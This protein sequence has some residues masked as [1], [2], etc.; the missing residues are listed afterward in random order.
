MGGFG[1]VRTKI[2]LA[3]SVF[4]IIFAYI[5]SSTSYF[6]ASETI[7][8]LNHSSLHQE[9]KAG[10]LFMESH[11]KDKLQITQS[12][13]QNI[14]GAK[15]DDEKSLVEILKIIKDS[16]GFDLTFVGFEKD[17]R[18]FRNNGKHSY[19]KDG[20]DP[21]TR[22]W[23]IDAKKN[24]TAGVSKAYITTTSKEMAVTFYAPFYENGELIGVVGADMSLASL[25]NETLKLKSSANNYAFAIDQDSRII[26]H[27][28]EKLHMQ[29]VEP[30]NTIFKSFGKVDDN[31]FEYNENIP[32]VASCEK[33]DS[34]G[35][36][37][38]SSLPQNEHDKY[39]SKQLTNSLLVGSILIIIGVVSL[40]F[41]IRKM[42]LA[43][44]CIRSGLQNFFDLLSNKALSCPPI[45]VNSNDEFGAM[46]TMINNN[47]TTVQDQIK[48][49]RKL[50]N[51]ARA[52]TKRMQNGFYSELIQESTTNGSLEELKNGVNDTIVATKERFLAIDKILKQYATNDYRSVVA[53]DGIEKS[54]AFQALVD[55]INNLRSSIVKTMQSAL[56]DGEQLEE[57]SKTLRDAIQNLS[58]GANE[59]ASSLE[60]SAASI[61]QLTA[62]M[63]QMSDKFDDVVHQSEEIR[64]V[65]SIIK[66]IAEQTN[67]LALNAAIEAARAGEQGR[68]FAVVADE[69]RKLA[70]RTQKSLSEI[71]ASVNILVQSI[72]DMS[73]S[74]QEQTSGISQINE[75]VSNLDRLTQKNA[76]IADKT[77]GIA[78]AVSKMAEDIVQEARNKKI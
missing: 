49:D 19:P 16:G 48:Q 5:L 69:V 66:D 30:F 64:N 44:E 63:Q 67:L 41:L 56:N 23:F 51:N 4:L 75:A 17:G 20:Y 13:A 70:E 53:L 43:I 2:T 33:L 60:E 25:Q 37:F 32:R 45:K 10:A 35:W 73:H 62:S 1:S 29:S 68:G 38:C 65:I 11:L 76:T 59:Q 54:G 34:L 40:Y 27:P 47:I 14:S 74:V 46:A 57:Q 39:L 6:V 21:R 8:I 36:I 50:I 58:Q 77:E 72:N 9:S 55:G 12:L 7:N 15:R 61:E 31:F 78:R 42:L 3:L 26:I 28:D 24:G 71:D 52:V 22:G 18:F